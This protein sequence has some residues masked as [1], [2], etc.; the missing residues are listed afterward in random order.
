MSCPMDVFSFTVV[1]WGLLLRSN[2]DLS[3]MQRVASAAD[4]SPAV[5]CLTAY[6]LMVVCMLVSA[7]LVG[8]ASNSTILRK[9]RACQRVSVRPSASV[10][11]TTHAASTVASVDVDVP[12]ANESSVARCGHCVPRQ[13]LGV[14]IVQNVA[15]ISFLFRHPE[16]GPR[17]GD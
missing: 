9:L 16:P 12:A 17:R 1:P 4:L 2:R 3:W 10:P 15:C 7:A 11:S 8:G 6:S 14:F 5:V 13:P